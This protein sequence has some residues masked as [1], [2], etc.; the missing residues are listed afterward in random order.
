[1]DELDAIYEKGNFSVNVFDFLREFPEEDLI[2]VVK[3]IDKQE[4]SWSFT[5]AM[6]SYFFCEMMKFIGVYDDA[7]QTE[8]EM[9]NALKKIGGLK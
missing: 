3:F 9:I 1:M 4:E 7:Y 2:N 6:A 8:N 5:E